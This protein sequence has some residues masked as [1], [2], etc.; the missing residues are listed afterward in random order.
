MKRRDFL[1]ALTLAAI[2][3][4]A[5]AQQ[6][7]LVEVWRSP[8]CGCCGAWVKHLEEN[9]FATRVHM[10]EDTASVRRRLGMPERLGSCH[11]AK[12]GGYVVEGHVPASDIRRLL[13]GRPKALGLAAPGMPAASPGMDVPGSPPYDVL[14]VGDGGRTSVFARHPGT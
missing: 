1:A 6:R 8:S 2:A 7:P 5:L 9:G 12:V 3:P 11:T 4:A 10:V 13:A 14:L